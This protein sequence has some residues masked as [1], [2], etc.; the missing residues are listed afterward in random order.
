MCAL[1]IST[2][3][4]LLSKNV[5]SLFNRIFK[6][7]TPL[8]HL[9][10][11]LLSHY[12]VSGK[13]T[14]DSLIQRLVSTGTNPINLFFNSVRTKCAHQSCGVEDSLKYLVLHDNL[15][16]SSQMNIIWPHY[17]QRPS[18]QILADLATCL[19]INV[20]PGVY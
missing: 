11:V 9:Q 12:L 17:L 19:V 3:E 16:S 6:V 4:D 5:S 18:S 2:T 1:D 10:A 20:L 7:D 13:P 8:R 15:S 14:R